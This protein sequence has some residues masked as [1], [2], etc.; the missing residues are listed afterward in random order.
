MAD[1]YVWVAGKWCRARVLKGPLPG[2]AHALQIQLYIY[3][4]EA[5]ENYRGPQIGWRSVAMLRLSDQQRWLSDSEV[6]APV[7]E[8][9]GE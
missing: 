2:T 7:V 9:S 5:P 3:D 4:Y 6:G 8:G 1:V